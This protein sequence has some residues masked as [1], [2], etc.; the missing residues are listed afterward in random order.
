MVA[1]PAEAAAGQ[2]IVPGAKKVELDHQLGWRR[3]LR[4][5][6]F[7]VP[8]GVLVAMLVLSFLGPLV[9][10]LPNPNGGSLL[11]ANLPPFSVGHILGTDTYGNDLL[12]RC[13]YGGRISFEVGFGSVAIGMLI[14][15]C[16]GVVSG[17]KGRAI[18]IGIMR[19]LD[20][21]LAFPALIIAMMI[22]TYLGGSERNVIFAISF[23]TIPAFARLSRGVTLR[24]K[25]RTFIEASRMSGWRDSRIM[26]RHIAPNVLPSLL[27]YA[28]LTTSIAMI[29]EATLSFLGL[30][31]PPPAP[32]WGNLISSGEAVLAGQSY[33]LIAPSA[34]LFVSVLS[35][36]LLG[37]A[38]RSRWAAGL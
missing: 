10:P 7:Y 18:E 31:I 29:V 4:Q 8:A 36:N 35:L 6:E 16:L 14:G 17:F 32:S 12:S 23:F 33:L 2:L 3:R 9:L 11:S 37:D 15:G 13:I 27:T 22:A 30:G 25:E 34:F 19:G 24:I 5:A 38:I 21:L 28:L 1:R 20:M 26:L